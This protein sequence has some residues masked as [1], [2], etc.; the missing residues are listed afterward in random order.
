M[1]REIL[2]PG[3]I[4]IAREQRYQIVRKVGSGGFGVTYEA[5]RLSDSDDDRDAERTRALNQHAYDRVAVKEFYPEDI[6]RKVGG[7]VV[8]TDDDGAADTFDRALDRFKREAERLYFLTRLRAL[9]AALAVP[10][11]SPDEAEIRDTISRIVTGHSTARYESSPGGAQMLVERLSG[12]MA[13]A[14]SMALAHSPLPIVHD[15]FNTPTTAYYVMEFLGGG[16][17]KDR[18]VAR[19]RE[20]GERRVQSHGITYAVG[21]PW[22]EPALKSFA[23]AA[24]EALEELHV[25]IP[26]QQLVHCDLK[27][28]NIMFRSANSQDPVLIDF[29]LARN[30]SSDRSRI[31]GGGT[32]GYAAI[33]I[34]PDSQP[35][36]SRSGNDAFGNRVGP[37]TDIYA[38]AV[39]LR[40][41][42]TGLDS[43]DFPRAYRR[44]MEVQAKHPDPVTMLPPFGN[45][46]DSRFAR[47]VDRGYAVAV[48]D[49]PQSVGEWR[50]QLGLEESSRTVA[51]DRPVDAWDPYSGPQRDA[52]VSAPSTPSRGSRGSQPR[53]FVDTH[54]EDEKKGFGAGIFIA[55]FLVAVLLAVGV[56]GYNVL[57]GDH[58][59]PQVDDS[60]NGSATDND[61]NG[62]PV[63]VEATPTPTPT[64]SAVPPPVQS[65]AP[66]PTPAPVPRATPTPRYT[67]P[68]VIYKPAAPVPPPRQ[69]RDIDGQMPSSPDG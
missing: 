30:T 26:G 27:P 39:I 20:F 7:R 65:F 4:L 19:K 41:L 1:E 68:P 62:A 52:D 69:S 14:A 63:D 21:E 35:Y 12:P 9:R 61:T 54:V 59:K 32:P 51:V 46:Y 31:L 48:Q 8:P 64:P 67:P 23:L 47:G 60:G 24:L 13:D 53:G 55:I 22:S 2:L 43:R 6:A 16:S 58:D 44:M 33:E 34:D 49:R 42:G 15:Y 29:G 57:T 45:A 28:G 37:W 17:L 56:F 18:N 40:N 3:H 11:S 38:L 66:A 25:G 50:R 36:G 10:Q 5:T